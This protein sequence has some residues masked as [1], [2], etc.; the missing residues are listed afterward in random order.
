MLQVV[1]RFPVDPDDGTGDPSIRQGRFAG[2]RSH[3]NATIMGEVPLVGLSDDRHFFESHVDGRV[4]G[5]GRMKRSLCGLAVSKWVESPIFIDLP[6][7]VAKLPNHFDRPA[8][9][10]ESNHSPYSEEV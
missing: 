6:S 5:P 2:N 8:V 3:G 7:I 10:R 1:E 4:A 9:I